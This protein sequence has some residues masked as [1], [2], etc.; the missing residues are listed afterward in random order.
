MNDRYTHSKVSAIIHSRWQKKCRTTRER[1]EEPTPIKI[2]QAWIAA[3]AD[4]DDDD[5]KEEEEKKEE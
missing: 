3:A 1:L 4:D 5:D 2:E